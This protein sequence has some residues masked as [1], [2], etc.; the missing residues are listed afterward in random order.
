MLFQKI[1]MLDEGPVKR[2]V[3][4]RCPDGDEPSSVAVAGYPWNRSGDPCD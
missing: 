4:L 3:F 1:E 2:V